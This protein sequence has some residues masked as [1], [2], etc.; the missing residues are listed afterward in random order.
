[1]FIY[2]YFIMISLPMKQQEVSIPLIFNSIVYA[3]WEE[4]SQCAK[5]FFLLSQQL[6]QFIDDRYAIFLS[7]VTYEA[8][9]WWIMYDA[10]S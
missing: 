7:G 4:Y 6:F 9:H 8:F 3:S 5:Y 1:M 10:I 2:Y